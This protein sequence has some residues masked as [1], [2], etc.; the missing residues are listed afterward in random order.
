MSNSAAEMIRRRASQLTA[1]LNVAH[2]I[3]G[4]PMAGVGTPALAAAVSNAGGLGALGAGMMEP[5]AIEEAV[6]RI[7]AL[8]AQ[9]FAVNLFV[10]PRPEGDLDQLTRM[11]ARLAR[12]RTELGLAR[13]KIPSRFAPDFDAQFDA[14][15]AA[16]VPVVSFTFG[17]LERN[18]IEALHAQGAKVIGTATCVREARLLAA[19]GCD[20]VVAS[21]IEA[22]GH[23]ATFAVPFEQAQVGLFALLPQVAMAVDVPVIAAGAVMTARQAAAA[24]WLGASGVQLGSALLRTPESGAGAA[25]REA[26]ATVE[27]IGTRQTRA[28][29]GRPA[30]GVINRVMNEI[31]AGGDIPPYPL[32]NKLTSEIRSAAGEQGKADYL[33]LWAGQ[34]AALAR[35]LPAEQVVR[36]MALELNQFLN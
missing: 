14:V 5:A 26:L 29:S 1:S 12:Y 23:R 34:A 18:R 7:R 33:S 32:Q 8:T 20:A 35:E 2:P 25:Y 21:G 31:E 13:Q 28:F 3:I 36:D 16:R 24:M 15:L 22:G 19:V 30:R 10:T 6:S 27:D 11:T 4:G 17:A 9:P